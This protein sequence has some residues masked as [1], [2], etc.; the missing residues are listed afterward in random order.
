[1]FLGYSWTAK[2]IRL[3]VAN[4]CVEILITRYSEVVRDNLSTPIVGVVYEFDLARYYS[5]TGLHHGSYQG[6]RCSTAVVR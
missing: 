4:G 3:L 1:M 6:S 5:Q 2:I